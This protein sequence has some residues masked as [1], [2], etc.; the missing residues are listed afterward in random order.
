MGFCFYG[1]FF[2]APFLL[3]KRGRRGMSRGA[4]KNTAA[5]RRKKARGGFFV[6]ALF[7]YF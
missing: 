5:A 1:A 7:H 6:A 2:E 3:K 4:P